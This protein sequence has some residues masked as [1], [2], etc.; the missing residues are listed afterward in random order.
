MIRLEHVCKTYR[1]G[2]TLVRALDD[3]SLEIKAGEFV[4]IMGASG[5]GKSTLMHLLGLLDR[6]TSGSHFLF[7]RDIAGLNED[8]SAILR[9]RTVGFVFQ[10]FHL[11]AR[12]SAEENVALPALYNFDSVPRSRS[13][14]LL[15]A[16]GLGERLHHKPNELSGGQ[17]QRVAIARSLVNAPRILMADEPTGNL[18]SASAAEI[19]GLLSELNRRGI[20]IILVTHEPDLAVY[21]KRIVRLRDGKILSDEPNTPPE[22]P[23]LGKTGIELFQ[24]LEKETVSEQLSAVSQTSSLLPSRRI[25]FWGSVRR[26]GPLLRQAFRSVAAAKVR[27]ALS[28]LGILIGVAAIIAML[29]LGT[30]A[31]LAMQ[32]QISSMGSNLLFL[33]PGATQQKGVSQ[34]IGASTRLTLE[35]VAAL[36]TE[37]AT[38]RNTAPQLDARYQAV[39]G[40]RN[41]SSYVLGTTPPH[42]KMRGWQMQ[43]GRFFTEEEVKSRARVAVLGTTV[44]RELFDEGVNPVGEYIRVNKIS[45]QVVGV[46]GTKGASTF[47]DQDDVIMIPVTTALYRLMGRRFID[48][49]NI[50]VT[51]M[52]ALPMTMDRI[53]EVMKR[54]HRVPASQEEPFTIRNLAEFQEALMTVTRTMSI[55]LS[56]IAVISLLVGGIGIM[57]IMLVSVTERTR[58]IGLRKAIGARRGEIMMQFL[59]EALAISITGGSIGIALG[60]GVSAALSTFAEWPTSVSMTAVVLAFGFSGLVGIVFGLWPARKAALLNPIE[61]LR[62]E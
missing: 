30:G 22:L 62:Y 55:L 9:S 59:V 40:N 57:N 36:K 46:L 10:Q 47:G 1:M 14:A 12:T 18:D 60:W 53:M 4:A 11:L 33:Y 43:S 3:V 28:M 58:E 32:K 56:S 8:E 61:A 5:S 2:D 6:P 51:D 35:D 48:R 21:A 26:I 34:Q 44:Q 7:G 49:I 16:I 15:K 45:F 23:S 19:M 41:W 31:K 17:Q 20:T 42:L 52:E 37:I 39:Y 13:A 24:T 54:L 25:R 27:S 29:A 50:E 38:V